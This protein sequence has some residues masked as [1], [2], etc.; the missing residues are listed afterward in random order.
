MENK[1]MKVAIYCRV[2]TDEQF[3]DKQEDEIG[4]EIGRAH[5]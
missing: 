1:I 2:S 3:A 4:R 5:V